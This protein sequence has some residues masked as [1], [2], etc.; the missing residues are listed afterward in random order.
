[1]RKLCSKSAVIAAVGVLWSVTG[2][3][4]PPKLAEG[5]QSMAHCFVVNLG[6]CEWRIAISP[7]AGGEARALRLAARASQVVDIPGGEYAIEQTLLTVDAGTDSVRRF[8][9]RIEVGQTYRWRLATLLTAPTGETGR[10]TASDR[11]E[12]ER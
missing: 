9:V 3:G 6:D 7:V 2:C 1:M 11:H 10:D 12:R 8:S 5:A 4:T